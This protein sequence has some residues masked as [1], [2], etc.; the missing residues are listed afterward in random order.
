MSKDLRKKCPVCGSMFYPRDCRNVFCSKSCRQEYLKRVH[1]HLARIDGEKE[2]RLFKEAV[3]R[4]YPFLGEVEKRICVGCGK[5]FSPLKKQQIYCHKKCGTVHR[6]SKYYPQQ[7]AKNSSSPEIFISR[8]LATNK[9]Y[10]KVSVDYL[11]SLYNKQHGRCALS[12]R[13]MT[14]I[15]GYGRISTNISID[16]IDSS[17]DYME[18]NVQL[19]CARVNLMKGQFRQDDFV[20]LCKDIA[21]YS[22]GKNNE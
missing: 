6:R 14:Y 5:E 15:R 18:G 12:G 16:R 17:K 13:E 4:D 11:M 9:R 19:V 1:Q 10:A 7:Y 20:E 3:L 8:L 21:E 2:R 22:K